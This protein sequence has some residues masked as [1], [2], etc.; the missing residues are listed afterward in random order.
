MPW[1]EVSPMT[2]RT[3]FIADYQRGAY[4]VDELCRRYGVS[5]TTG[6]KLINLF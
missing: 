3:R 6:Y 4:S 1:K 2:E 5:R